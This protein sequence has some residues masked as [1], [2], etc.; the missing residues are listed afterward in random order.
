MTIGD[1][2]ANG[3]IDIAVGCFYD[4]VQHSDPP[5]AV[6]FWNDGLTD[7]AD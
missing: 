1:F 4:A 6:V 2:N 5:I 7:R 3:R